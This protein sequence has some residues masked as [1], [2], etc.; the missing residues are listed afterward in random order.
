MAGLDRWGANIVESTM[1]RQI[2]KVGINLTPAL[3]RRRRRFDP[4]SG[5]AS[6]TRM[7]EA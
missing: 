7:G 5:H 1:T 3:K 4:V 6:R 2:Y